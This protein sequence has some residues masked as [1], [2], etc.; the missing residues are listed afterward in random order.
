LARIYCAKIFE[1]PEERG[2]FS[3]PLQRA[4]SQARNSTLPL[5]SDIP[6]TWGGFGYFLEI[7]N[8][9]FMCRAQQM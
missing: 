7:H 3:L 5:L 2:S 4:C 9:L 6:V 1:T 8:N